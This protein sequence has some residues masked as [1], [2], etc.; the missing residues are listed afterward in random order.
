MRI[1]GIT[2]VGSGRFNVPDHY[3][4]TAG[5]EEPGGWNLYTYVLADPVN[6]ID[7]TG[8]GECAVGKTIPCT[9]TVTDGTTVG[10]RTVVPQPIVPSNE[11]KGDL[12]G[13]NPCPPV[14]NAPSGVTVDKNVAAA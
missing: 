7:A 11:H 12:A 4:N 13:G 8:E 14:P 9:A 6:F 2:G 10:V 1:S 5:L 3:T